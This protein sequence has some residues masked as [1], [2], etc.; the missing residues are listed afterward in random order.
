M[1]A[2]ISSALMLACI[3]PITVMGD[4][5]TRS[6][7]RHDPI[8][9]QAPQEAWLT[10]DQATHLLTSVEMI[11]R[12]MQEISRQN[13]APRPDAPG[14]CDPSYPGCSLVDLSGI[15]A[16]L[17]LIE[18][19][20]VCLCERSASQQETLASCCDVIASVQDVVGACTDISTVL[21]TQTDKSDID[22][23]CLSV[24]SLL[25]TVLLELRGVF[26]NIP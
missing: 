11:V 14:S 13:K 1:I 6:P 15:L 20:L 4:E 17:C 21:P 3:V 12:Q 18:N 25:K 16:S 19:Q 5:Q 26:T 7:R 10:K 24:V 23:L 22:A 9:L 8:V 2:R